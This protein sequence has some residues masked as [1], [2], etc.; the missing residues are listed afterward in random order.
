MVCVYVKQRTQKY[1]TESRKVWS[2]Q[3]N[4][5]NKMTLSKL[6]LKDRIITPFGFKTLAFTFRPRTHGVKKGPEPT[7]LWQI[8]L[9]THIFYTNVRALG[10]FLTPCLRGGPR[11]PLKQFSNSKWMSPIP[12]SE[13]SFLVLSLPY[14]FCLII[15]RYR[16]SS[17]CMEL[18]I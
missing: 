2:H 9:I 8:W 14:L 13:F 15:F 3:L 10:T 11:C 4:Y 7:H 18:F 16:R 17:L 6:L 5:K 12:L 1:Q